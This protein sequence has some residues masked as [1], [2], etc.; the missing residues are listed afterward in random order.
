MRTSPLVAAG[1]LA[2]GVLA[3]PV[4]AVQAFHAVL[5]GTN[6]VPAVSSSG[7]GF[8]KVYISDAL[9]V[10]KITANF[11]GL[12]A[13]TIAAHVHCCGLAGTNAG[14]AIETPSLPGF[15]LGVT[16]GTF[17]NS[18]SLLDPLS[19]NPAYVTA[20]GGTA[21]GARDALIA[22]LN[23]DK[24]YFNIHSTAFRGGEIRGQ[25]AAVPE[26]ASW[27]LLITGFGMVGAT[28]RRRQRATA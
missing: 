14:V 15:P 19:Y 16:S 1:V 13:N 18:F 23:G 26:P 20:N 2:F 9:D 6:E 5:A 3:A 28:L 11:T 12:G 24:A 4:H 8:A 21:I 7:T 22:G 10:I 25:F 17:T 27:A